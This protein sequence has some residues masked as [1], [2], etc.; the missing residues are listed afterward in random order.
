MLL[1]IVTWR[2]R[3][4]ADTPSRPWNIAICN[5][6]KVDHV[7]CACYIGRL[8]SAAASL[9]QGGPVAVY[10]C[11]VVRATQG[12]I[13]LNVKCSELQEQDQ[14][15]LHLYR[16]CLLK[17]VGIVDRV[18]RWRHNTCGN[19]FFILCS[20]TFCQIY[21]RFEVQGLRSSRAIPNLKT[22]KI[23]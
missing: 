21:L 15:V 17:I 23:K 4:P 7:A 19:E 6:H 1:T 14:S 18:V 5:E 13:R 2:H 20:K 8:V 11:Q 12:V 3:T 16:F 22:L 10:D 9:H